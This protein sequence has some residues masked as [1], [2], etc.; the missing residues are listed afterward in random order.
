MKTI[1]PFSSGDL[2]EA[3]AKLGSNINLRQQMVDFLKSSEK[4][5][6]VSGI[7]VRE[8]ISGPIVDS[9]Y[10]P[11]DQI[12][13]TLSSGLVITCKY[14]S[15]IARD[16]LMSEE[17]SD[18]VWEPQTTKLL[19]ELSEKAK[20]VIVGGAYF[21]DQALLLAQSI[22][23]NAGVCHC[24]EVNSESLEMLRYNAENNSL[25]NMVINFKGLWKNDNTYLSIVGEDSH[26]GTI[27]TNKGIQAVTIATYCKEKGINKIELIM[28]DVEGGEF[29]ILQGA[30]YFLKK[31][32]NE[33]P[34]LIFEVH[35]SYIDWSHGLE[36]TDII[37]YLNDLGYTSFA[38][39]DYQG[40]VNMSGRPIEIIPVSNIYLEG[41]PHGFN[42][43]AIKDITLV[44]KHNLKLC[45][46]VSPKLILHKNPKIFQPL[47]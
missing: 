25:N 18:H 3:I 42:M 17:H 32:A 45:S 12:V 13:K 41:P 9:L 35:R 27:E 31:N 29:A 40:N 2:K 6:N 11:D 8:E 34:N 44:E 28:V 21:G 26:A 20:N 36:N 4:K 23:K 39:R 16:F 46:G 30:E 33:A 24:F 1:K 5:L 10:G 15:K 7:N 37:K 47:N 38:I 43:L 19:L 14:R 22:K